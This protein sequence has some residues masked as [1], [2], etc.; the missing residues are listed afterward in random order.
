MNKGAESDGETIYPE[1]SADELDW[2]ELAEI[3]SLFGKLLEYREEISLTT[4]QLE[5]LNQEIAS[6]KIPFNLLCM[7]DRELE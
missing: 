5:N 2:R 4:L 7:R 1:P 6:T 3:Q